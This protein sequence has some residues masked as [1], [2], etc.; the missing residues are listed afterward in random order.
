MSISYHYAN[1][2]LT[3]HERHAFHHFDVI[4]QLADE[5]V[6]LSTVFSRLE[7]G[8]IGM[9]VH[10]ASRT[11]IFTR[12]F[13]S[14]SLGACSQPFVMSISRLQGTI[15]VVISPIVVPIPGIS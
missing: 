7:L 10:F 12:C 4:L 13:Q 8:G 1:T 14:K 9:H 6:E 5:S 15:V 2:W 11:D 3:V